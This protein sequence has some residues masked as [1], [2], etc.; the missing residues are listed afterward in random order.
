[1]VLIVWNW[2]TT[3]AEL[4]RYISISAV[5]SRLGILINKLLCLQILKESKGIIGEV[6]FQLP[7]VAEFHQEPA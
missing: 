7:V 2:K 6:V 1:M 4:K 5:V 3:T